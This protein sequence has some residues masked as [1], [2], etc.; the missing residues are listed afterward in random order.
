MPKF[1]FHVRAGSELEPDPSG[2]DF[3]SAEAAK[4]DATEAAREI[5]SDM[6]L[7]GEP[8]D[9]E[10][11]EITDEVGNLVARVPFRSVLRLE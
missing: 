11:F 2:V 7:T 9:G 8:I 6:V 5:L 3:P 4:S 1:Y 10:T